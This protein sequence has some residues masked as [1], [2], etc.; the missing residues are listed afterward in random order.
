MNNQDN[1]LGVLQTIYRWRKAIRNVCLLVLLGSI[2]FALTLKNFYQATTVFY[3]AGPQLANPELLFG[4]SGQVTDYYGG[5][6]E[7]DRMI[8]IAGGS[9]LSNYM[10]RKFNLYVHYRIDSTSKKGQETVL[11]V[12]R[13]LF[14]VQKNKNDAIELSVEDTDPQLAADMANAA[15]DRIDEIAQRLTKDSQAKLLL[16]FDDNLRRKQID[17]THLADTLRRM[18]RYYGIYATEAQGEQLSEQLTL[19]EAEITKNRG[20]LEVLENNPLIPRDTIAYIKA[21]L[22]AYERQ[23]AQ[24]IAPKSA[25]GDLSIDRYNEGLSD[26]YVLK[27]LHFQARK[28]LSYDIE[29][30]NQIKSA[31]NTAIPTVHVVES[32]QIPLVKSRPKR[33]ILVITAVLAAFLFTVLGAL[34]ADAY[35]EINWKA[36]KG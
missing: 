18:Q 1:L 19:A 2:G 22:R 13:S 6:R 11:K 16:A 28:Q 10:I 12:F 20:R 25:N 4:S 15:R 26:I 35:K 24:L 17:L 3:P 36:I 9:E 21:N 34:F 27:D 5:D 8:E 33:S 31:Y 23:R 7:L 29:R 30:Y 32:A 14:D